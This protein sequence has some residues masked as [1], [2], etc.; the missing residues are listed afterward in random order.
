MLAS[1]WSFV[2]L[3]RLVFGFGAGLTYSSGLLLLRAG[4][5]RRRH[6]AA[7]AAFGTAWALG[8]VAAAL[9]GESELASGVMICSMGLVALLRLRG[10]PGGNA[11]QPEGR[12][13]GLRELRN[14]WTVG[15]RVMLI[16]V[17]AGLLGQIAITTWGPRSASIEADVS[18]VALGLLVAAGIAVGNWI[19]MLA[20]RSSRADR[21]VAAS[22]I[23]T[24]LLLAFFALAGG[25]E[26]LRLVA[27]FLT[28]TASLISFPPGTARIFRETPT[29]LQPLATATVNQSGWIASAIGPVLLGLWTTGVQPPVE[30]W[31][32]L[33]AVTIV[34]GLAALAVNGRGARQVASGRA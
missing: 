31:L 6:G 7:V 33:A 25:S 11:M 24:G 19:G 1:E 9:V 15:V 29:N 23:L 30:A 17:P 32:T 8:E 12:L 14:I 28:V 10:T 18:V 27:V 13:V 3:G 4:V 20:G 21:I 26:T 2:A 16:V 34:A 5:A 22:P